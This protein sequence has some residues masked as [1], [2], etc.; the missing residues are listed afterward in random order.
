MS[1]FAPANFHLN[2]MVGIEKPALSNRRAC[3]AHAVMHRVAASALVMVCLSTF[4]CPALG[5]PSA[6]AMTTA[7]NCCAKMD[8]CTKPHEHASSH[9]GCAGEESQP[10][11]CCTNSCSTLIL[12]CPASVGFS[13][14]R[15][16]GSLVCTGNATPYAR[17]EQ[18]PIPPPRV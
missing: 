1:I 15:F 6:F 8:G 3:Y 2:Q 4:L 17:L 16:T 10:S 9:N 14:P 18:P 11:S 13:I 12:F 5:K 7:Q